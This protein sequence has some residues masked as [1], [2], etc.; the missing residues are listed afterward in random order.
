MLFKQL[1][2]SILNFKG[3]KRANQKIHSFNISFS[4]FFWR[5]HFLNMHNEWTNLSSSYSLNQV[6]FLRI[7]QRISTLW[8]QNIIELIIKA[9]ASLVVQLVKNPPAMRETRVQSLG[10]EDLLEKGRLPTPV[11]WPVKFHEVAESQTWLS[12]FHFHFQLRAWL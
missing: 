6:T 12:D 9:I 11:F 5:I 2:H 1:K 7:L 8:R 4:F 3:T 10:C